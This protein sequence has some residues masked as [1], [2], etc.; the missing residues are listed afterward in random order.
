MKIKARALLLTL[1]TLSSVQVA[2]AFEL[3]PLKHQKPYLLELRYGSHEPPQADTAIAETSTEFL[4]NAASLSMRIAGSDSNQIASGPF[5]FGFTLSPSQQA[6]TFSITF[7]GDYQQNDSGKTFQGAAQ[8]PLNEWAVLAETSSTT[9]TSTGP[10]RQ[11]FSVM[12][13]LRQ[14]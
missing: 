11:T 14:D 7:Q 5:T 13:R 9:I 8:I 12:M 4:A 3:A 10:Q 1:T 6:G 2:S